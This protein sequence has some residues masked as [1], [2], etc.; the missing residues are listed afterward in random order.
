MKRPQPWLW[1]KRKAW[2]VELGGKQVRL[3]AAEGTAKNP[4]EEVMREY[5]RRMMSVGLLTD[6]ER[7]QSTVPDVVEAFIASKADKAPNTIKS[8]LIYLKPFAAK[9]EV[10]R[11]HSLKIEEV[12][13]W[14]KGRTT[15]SPGVKHNCIDVIRVMFKWAHSKGFIEQNTMFDL[16]NPYPEPSRER[17]ITSEE[18]DIL[19]GATH[20]EKFKTVLRFLRDVGCRPGDLCKV[21]ARHLHSE[22]PV[23][24]LQPDEHKTGSRTHKPKFLILTPVIYSQLKELAKSNPDT[25][26]YRNT[27]G[28]AW[29]PSA[30]EKRFKNLRIRKSLP[31]FVIAYGARHALITKLVDSGVPLAKVCK[32]IGHKNPETIMHSY[33]TPSDKEMMKIIEDAA[34]LETKEQAIA[35]LR[36]EIAQRQAE[37][38]ALNAGSS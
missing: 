21:S 10:Q 34:A 8:Y 16:P 26:L 28:K 27:K 19:I 12:R 20:D 32:I 5:H 30:I 13:D 6:T 31:K 37:I 17:G 3:G 22:L 38:E 36:A 29:T 9:F 23:A 2:Y 4:P 18:F 33:Y 25:P 7:E 11:I 14:V 24:T 15:W 1:A 35:R